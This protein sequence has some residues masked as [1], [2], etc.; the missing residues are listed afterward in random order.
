MISMI[1][2]KSLFFR[3]KLNKINN[4]T[5]EFCFI[6]F[7]KSLPIILLVFA[8]FALFILGLFLYLNLIFHLIEFC[9]VNRLI[10]FLINIRS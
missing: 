10:S 1:E 3:Q 4:K 5:N 7:V 2:I 9:K 8:P 6:N